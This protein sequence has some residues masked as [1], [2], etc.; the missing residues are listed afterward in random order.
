MSPTLALPGRARRGETRG[1]DR[2]G[3]DVAP[4]ADGAEQTS[5]HLATKVATGVLMTCLVLGPVGAV[6]GVLA[7]AQATRPVA[8]Q[9]APVVDRANDRAIAGEFAQRVV[10]TWLTTTQD[11]PDPLLAL[12]KDAQVSTL[13]REAFAVKDPTVA[14]IAL[15]DGT[16]SVTVA[17]TVTDVRGSTVRRFFQVPVRLAGGTVT[18]LTLPTPVSPPQ[19]TGASSS[20]YRVQ[21]GATSAPGQAVAQFL[22]AY[23]AGS[24]DVSRYLTP[25]VSLTPLNPAPYTSVRL[26]DLRGAAEATAT[27]R[28]GQGLRVLAAATASV[29]DNQ[30]ASVAYALTLTARAGRWEISAID[31]VPAFTPRAPAAGSAAGSAPPSTPGSASTPTTPGTSSPAPT[32]S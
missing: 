14:G 19:V 30:G 29:T 12:V 24:G 27:P 9:S 23:I 4:I 10:V 32:A 5:S 21:V 6:V 26:D 13:S 28:D 15:S 31:V 2:S 3:E 20:E 11:A 1:E 22:S 25:G 18:A 16:W 17:A 8:L 7:L